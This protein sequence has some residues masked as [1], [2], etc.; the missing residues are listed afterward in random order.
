MIVEYPLEGSDYQSTCGANKDNDND[1]ETQ[2]QPYDKDKDN[3]KNK[4]TNKDNTNDK[5]SHH[6]IEVA[7]V[8]SCHVCGHGP[9]KAF[10]HLCFKNY[11]LQTANYKLQVTKIQKNYKIQNVLNPSNDFKIEIGNCRL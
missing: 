3:D 11:K 7:W 1:K 2:Q 5:E 4:P 9:T 8:M 6:V 10:S